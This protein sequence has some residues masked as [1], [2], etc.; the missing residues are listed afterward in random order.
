MALR[1]RRIAFAV[2]VGAA[3]GLVACTAT[4]GADGRGITVDG[5][6]AT[7]TVSSEDFSDGG[8]LAATFAGGEA[9]CPGDNL[10]PQLSWTSGPE[11]TASYVIAV[12]DPD[13]RGYVHWLHVDIPTDI[14]SV[15]RG[16]SGSLPGTAGRGTNGTND[17]FGPCPPS[18][19]GY[20]FTVYALDAR[21]EPG[22]ALTYE[23]FTALAEDHVLA[24]GHITGYFPAS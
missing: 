6:S 12:I 23:E 22:H 8:D 24:A 13:A 2:L 5:V 14:R 1:H 18:R 3:F 16:A 10:N 20:V 21:I 17:Y 7:L 19:H 15:A 11:D 4:G 9:N